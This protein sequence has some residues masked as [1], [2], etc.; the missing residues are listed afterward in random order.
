MNTVTKVAIAGAIALTIGASVTACSSEP[1]TVHVLE[2]GYYSPTHV[3]VSSPTPYY[4]YVP[5]S[6]YN[7]HCNYYSTPAYATTYV[8]THTVTTVS[9]G[10]SING[11]GTVVKTTTT[12]KKR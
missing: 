12:T 10:Y 11:S 8:K 4:V 5:R 3:W 1:D 6:E 9:K 2:Y 7:A